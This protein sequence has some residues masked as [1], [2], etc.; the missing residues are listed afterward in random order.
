MTSTPE[1]PPGLAMRGFAPPRSL[2][3]FKLLAFGMDSALLYPGA[4]ELVAACTAAGMEIQLAIGELSDG[5]AKLAMLQSSCRAL[6]ITPAQTVVLGHN[7]S[8]LPLLRA[9]GLSA[10]YHADP[11]IAEHAMVAIHTGGFDRLLEVLTPHTTSEVLILNK[12]LDLGVLD[13]L[14]AHDA[15]KFQKFASLFMRSMET[16]MAEVDTAIA[17]EDLPVLVAMG[18]R[19]KSTALSIGAAAF[20]QQCLQMEKAACAQDAAAALRIARNLRPQFAAICHAIEQRLAT[21]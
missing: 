13:T 6:G 21:D 8:D 11:V 20:S 17:Q 7:A 18:H 9:A 16:V 1:F 19:A 5:D 3:E 15:A 14:V 12:D 10:T 4:E 2:S